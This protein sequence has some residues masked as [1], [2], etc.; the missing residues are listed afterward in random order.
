LTV[1]T[2]N[3]SMQFSCAVCFLR[4]QCLDSETQCSMLSVL[5]RHTPHP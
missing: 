4:G 2:M 3:R 1:N 5:L